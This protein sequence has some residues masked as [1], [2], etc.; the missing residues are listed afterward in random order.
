MGVKECI[1]YAT[2]VRKPMLAYEGG[3]HFT[4]GACNGVDTGNNAALTQKFIDANLS[5][6]MG[7]VYTTD[8][9]KWR[10][11]GGGMYCAF[12][13]LCEYTRWGSWGLLRYP[14]QNPTTAPKYQAAL[15]WISNNPA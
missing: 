1:D 8:L 3:Q 7:A 14:K 15:N 9:N 12:A 5:P 11:M 2:S 13:S 6:D 4:G 10:E